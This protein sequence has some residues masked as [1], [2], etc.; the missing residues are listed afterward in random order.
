MKKSALALLALL[1]AFGFGCV[2]K[3]VAVETPSIIGEESL[4]RHFKGYRTTVEIKARAA[5]LEQRLLDPGLLQFSTSLMKIELVSGKRFAKPGDRVDYKV[6]ALNFG[7]KVR[8][9]LIHYLPGREIWYAG[10]GGSAIMLFKFSLDEQGTVTRLNL[11]CELLEKGGSDFQ[12]LEQLV[13]LYKL[14]A[15]GFESVI[16]NLQV[17]F[18]PSLKKDE[19]L[20]KGIRGEFFESFYVGHQVSE[21]IEATGAQVFSV[22]Q[23][24]AF[25][26]EFER[27]SGVKAAP[28]FY[29]ISEDSAPGA[30]A[31]SVPLFGD[32]LVLDTVLSAHS[33]ERYTFNYFYWGDSRFQFV[34]DFSEQ[35]GTDLVLFYLTPSANLTNPEMLNLAL[36]FEKI[37]GLIKTRFLPLIKQRAEQLA[38][39]GGEKK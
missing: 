7:F 8:A 25:W 26:A 19:L 1:L 33:I 13:D 39:S 5:E 2:K 4:T 27:V 31:V 22:F 24:P 9:T 12:T 23:D 37:P 30:C 34:F 14:I 11:S 16:A 35:G 32:A 6:S 18:D 29:Q 38:E 10:S 36:N 15:Q 3:K 28:C 21:H 20:A 17:Q